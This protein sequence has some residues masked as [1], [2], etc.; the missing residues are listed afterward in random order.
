MNDVKPFMMALMGLEDFAQAN[1]QEG[2]QHQSVD[3]K[4]IRRFLLH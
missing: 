1:V 3:V 2:F 4:S